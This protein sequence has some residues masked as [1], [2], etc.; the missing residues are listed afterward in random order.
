M[1]TGVEQAGT[2]VTTVRDVTHEL[3]GVRLMVGVPVTV[4]VELADHGPG[5]R[6]QGTTITG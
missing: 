2:D 1:T 4:I 5:I 6:G 3:H